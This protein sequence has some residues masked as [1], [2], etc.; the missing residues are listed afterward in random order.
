MLKLDN[1]IPKA[2]IF[3]LKGKYLSDNERR[4]FSAHNPLGF[5]L[6]SRNIEDAKQV[7]QLVSDLKECVGRTD[8]P[9]LIDQEGG[10]VARLK[11]PHFR[12]VPPAGDFAA[13]A[14]RDV[15]LAKEAVY[16]NAWLIAAELVSLGITVDCAPVADLLIP[17]AHDIIGDRAYGTDPVQV[18]VLARAM[19]EGLLI[20]GVVPI[21]KHIPGHGRAKADSHEA[22]PVVDT[23]LATLEA[24]DFKVFKLLADAPW[25][26]TAHILYTALD[27]VSPATHSKTIIR[28]IREVIGFGGVLVSDDLSMKALKG[29]FAERTEK[30]L[31]AGCDV[32]LHCNGDM[33]E[34]EA[35][36]N[37]T[38][39]LT[40]M[41][42]KR[43]DAAKQRLPVAPTADVSQHQGRLE[44]ILKKHN[45]VL[46]A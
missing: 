1:T 36:A 45:K 11:K 35:I 13:I 30:V 22:L 5:I 6:F 39:A 17:G 23:D 9:I 2:A 21:I 19:C 4:F 16:L 10:R 24:T 34:M 28:Y 26:M 32:V 15:E 27:T 8:A 46:G 38:P 43:L 7:R 42:L 33:T 20:G 29:S 31:E 18:A 44:S 37:H 25:A 3:G 41:A 12:S 40:E 14:A